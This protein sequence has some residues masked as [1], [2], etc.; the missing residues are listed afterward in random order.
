ME[1]TT[2]EVE[3]FQ[4]EKL[5]IRVHPNREAAGVAAAKATAEAMKTIAANRKIFSVIF[6]TGASQI[7]TLK[8]LTAIPGLPWNQ[9]DG[10][11]MDDYVGL[12]LNHPA[13][14]RAYLEEKLVR[15]VPIRS[16]AYVFN[17]TATPEKTCKD[18]AEK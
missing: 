5:K 14:F 11:H 7:E 16:F 12:P 4:V 3:E 1:K 17:D 9:I 6:A 13:S 2:S 10:F 15:R 8:G 18:Y